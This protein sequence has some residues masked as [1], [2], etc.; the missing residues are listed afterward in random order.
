MRNEKTIL[1]HH[2]QRK[3]FL[4]KFKQDEGVIVGSFMLVGLSLDR[5]R[6][7]CSTLI[8]THFIEYAILFNLQKI[9]QMKLL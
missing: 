7:K 5:D 3:G 6:S 2:E 8:L 1:V 9:Y 4:V